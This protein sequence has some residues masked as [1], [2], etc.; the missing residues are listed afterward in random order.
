M[1]LS[2]TTQPSCIL[3]HGKKKQ[4]R[5]FIKESMTLRK[6]DKMENSLFFVLFYVKRKVSL[7]YLSHIV[8]SSVFL[9]T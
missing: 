5:F 7:L 4:T 6:F 3:C 8:T 9:H 1:T 2:K